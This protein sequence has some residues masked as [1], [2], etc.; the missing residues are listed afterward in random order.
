MTY[1]TEESKSEFSYR[2]NDL[3]LKKISVVEKN[4][5]I[6]ISHVTLFIIDKFNISNDGLRILFIVGLREYLFF[7][8]LTVMILYIRLTFQ[9]QHVFSNW[10]SFD[11]DL[12]TLII[13]FQLCSLSSILHGISNRRRRGLY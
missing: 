13:I 3:N 8:F 6:Y 11:N 7:V 12:H 1:A 10:I 4:I 2:E 5:I 9:F